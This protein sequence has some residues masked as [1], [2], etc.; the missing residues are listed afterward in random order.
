MVARLG[1]LGIAAVAE[2]LS[3]QAEIGPAGYSGQRGK[4]SR[5]PDLIDCL[6]LV[7]NG[8]PFDVAF[9]L[10][11]DERLAWIVAFG[12]IDGREFDWHTLRWIERS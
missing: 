8:V 7:R 11:P 4:L 2:A 1:D 12:T 9:S 6:F 10:P 5:H 3:G